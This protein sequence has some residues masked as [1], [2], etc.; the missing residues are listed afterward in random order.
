MILSWTDNELLCGQASAYRTHRRTVGHTDRQTLAT[1][2]P[3]GQNWSWVKMIYSTVN[4]HSVTAHVLTEIGFKSLSR[5]QCTSLQIS[6]FIAFNYSGDLLS[7]GWHGPTHIWSILYF[8]ADITIYQIY[9]PIYKISIVSC[10]K[11]PTSHVYAWQIGP[12][13]QD[14]LDICC[15]HQSLSSDNFTNS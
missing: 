9:W 14:T 4:L 3:H 1:T 13:W 2:L 12:F 11:G 7:T 6:C 10:Q 5:N 8:Q 15:L